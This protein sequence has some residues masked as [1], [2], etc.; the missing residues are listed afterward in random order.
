MTRAEE[1]L[2]LLC[3]PLGDAQERPLTGAQYRALARAVS[4][5]RHEDDTLRDLTA[6]DLEKL[7]CAGEEAERI[8]RLLGRE[9]QLRRYLAAAERR[10]FFALTRLSPDY[11]AAIRRK[12]GQDAP[13]ALFCAGDRTL[14][15][16]EGA[17]LVGS[18]A[19]LPAGERFA[20]AVGQ[21]AARED[22]VLVSGGAAGADTAAQ[23][24]C[25]AAGG[26]VV[27]FLADALAARVKTPPENA[28]FCAELG[29]DIPFSAPRALSRNRLIHA[30]PDRELVAQT[31]CGRGGTWAGTVE[32]LRRGWSDVYVRD[33]GTDGANALIERGATPVGP[34]GLPS[35]RALVP[36][37]TRLF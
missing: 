7:G 23:D 19:L 32:N 17:A 13:A 18:R 14:F 12:L 4:G 16:R 8:V 1:G 9:D 26:Q 27:C 2:L 28:L 10:G 25:I 5:A 30:L 36:N 33:D 35:I 21:T 6:R 34:D 11:P 31:D 15:A 3:C 24:A 37:Q 29:W 22:L 20:R